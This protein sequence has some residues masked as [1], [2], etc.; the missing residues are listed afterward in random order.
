MYYRYVGVFKLRSPTTSIAPGFLMI[1]SPPLSLR[2]SCLQFASDVSMTPYP[3][4]PH[5]A[6]LNIV[7][8]LRAIVVFLLIQHGGKYI[9]VG[10][11]LT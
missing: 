6:I 1:L 10:R 7:F 4:T 5:I 11:R 8:S 2:P 9:S 3:Y